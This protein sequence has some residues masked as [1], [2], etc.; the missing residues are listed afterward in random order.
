MLPL[1]VNCW[2]L[3]DQSILQARW[4]SCCQTNSIKVLNLCLLMLYRLR[5]DLYC[6]RCGI[7]LYSIQSNVVFCPYVG[8]LPLSLAPLWSV[9]CQL[10][11]LA[12]SIFPSLSSV[13]NSIAF[14]SVSLLPCSH[15]SSTVFTKQSCCSIYVFSKKYVSAFNWML[16]MLLYCYLLTSQWLSCWHG[17]GFCERGIST[18]CCHFRNTVPEMVISILLALGVCLLGSVLLSHGFFHDFAIFWLCFVIA[19]CQ[20]SLLKVS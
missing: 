4:P 17:Y 3:L 1:E 18:F 6:V 14:S 5:N 11:K 19:G 2:V 16:L 20:Y 7:K 10:L 15:P 13:T 12:Y 8:R 9:L